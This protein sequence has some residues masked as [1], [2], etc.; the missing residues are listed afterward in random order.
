MVG[1]HTRQDYIL[2]GELDCYAITQYEGG[3]EGTSYD[4]ISID[5]LFTCAY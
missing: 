2:L 1:F 3:E 4:N 5:N